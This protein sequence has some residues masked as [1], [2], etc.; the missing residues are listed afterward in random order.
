[1]KKQRFI[2]AGLLIILLAVCMYLGGVVLSVAAMVC[3][4]FAVYEEYHALG[5]KGH[6]PVAWPTW[7]GLGLGIPLTILLDTR[8]IAPILVLVCMVTSVSVIFRHEPKLEDILVSVMPLITIVLP[9]MALI[10]LALVQPEAVSVVLLCLTFVIPVLGDTMAYLVGSRVGGPKFCPAVSPN[11]TISG[12]VAGMAGSLVGA[13]LVGGIARMCC[14]PATCAILPNFLDY[15]ILGLLGGAAGQLGDLFASLIK[16][17]CGIKDFSN[18]FP[19]HGGMLDRL[20][21]I[22]FT[23]IIIFCYRLLM[24]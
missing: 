10:S 20:D 7:V 12:A 5:L 3:I 8:V 23:A 24:L 2:T 16:R 17:H 22:L 4:C 14:D 9:G 11:K 15:I 6:R 21:S 18:L 13:L 19:G 1:M